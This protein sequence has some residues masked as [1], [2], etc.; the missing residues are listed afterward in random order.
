NGVHH[1][2]TIGGNE[3]NTVGKK[4]LP[5]DANGLLN[6]SEIGPKL[7]SIVEN[8]LAA[9]AMTLGLGPHVVNVRTDLKLRGGPGAEFPVIKSLANGTALNVLAFDETSDG[10]WALVDLEGDGVKDGYVFAKFI[11][12]VVA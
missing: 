4:F 3:S 5:L 2:V 10:R 7:I 1:V 11:E 6:Q 9:G 8:Q 12:P